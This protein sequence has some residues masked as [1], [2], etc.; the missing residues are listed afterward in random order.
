MHITALTMTRSIFTAEIYNPQGEN[1]DAATTKVL[2]VEKASQDFVFTEVS[3]KPVLS[4][5]RN[6]S[7]P[8][9]L[10]VHDWH[11]NKSHEWLWASY[12]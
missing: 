11:L 8:V 5:L 6:F 1:G 9:K 7:A 12:C 3:E 10:Q 2:L 4:A